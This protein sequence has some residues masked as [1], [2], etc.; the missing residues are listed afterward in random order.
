MTFAT[1]VG[2]HRVRALLAKA[3]GQDLL[4]PALI[5]AGPA[6]IGKRRVALAVAE[7]LNCLNPR[8]GDGGERDACGKC[9]ACSRIARLVH[10]DVIV[11][12]P[13]EQGAIAIDVIRGVIDRAGY[14][15]FEG[16][17]RAVIIDDADAMTT[18]A[19][20]A[21]LKT[22][23]E[24]PSAS[25]F[26]LITSMPDALLPTV[27]SRCPRLRLAGLTAAEVA[28]VLVR[29]HD[30]D[31]HDARAAASD[32]DGSIGRALQA[33]ATELTSALTDAR[34]L[35]AVAVRGADGSRRIQLVKDLF[36]KKSTPSADRDHLATRLRA[37]G[38]LLRDLSI[39]LVGG[40]SEL[41][42]YPDLEAEL[43]RLSG[44]FDA[45][46]AGRAYAAVDR[47]LAALER[48][49]NA[50]IVGNWLAAQL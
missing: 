35:L 6:G 20:S 13:D 23:E 16:R 39:L 12:E 48:N 3:V 50:K 31:D 37:L 22:L 34:S 10:P 25:I 42:V 28:G 33:Q 11:V 47:A 19:Q 36:P 24:P 1:I 17:R 8:P 32:A 2:H 15:P 44:N 27:R 7:A 26:L 5:L 49:A 9:A 45:D 4:P 14:R 40:A 30:Y 43:K 29:D 46:R 21:L 38:A 18:H 41:L